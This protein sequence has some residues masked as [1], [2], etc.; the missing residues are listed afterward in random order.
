MAKSIPRRGIFYGWLILGVCFFAMFV[1]STRNGFGV[2]ILPM[3]EEFN[4][5]RGT[6]SLAIAIGMLVNGVS[7]PFLGRLH[8]RFGARK[9]LSAGLFLMGGCTMLLSQTNSIWFLLVI[10]GFVM[11]IAA[12]A[13]SM[14]VVHAALSRWFY[15]KRGIA[16]SVSTAGVSLGS[17]VLAPF[18]TYMIL[19]WD[20]R[21]AWFVLG[22]LILFLALPLVILLF[23]DNPADVGEVPDGGAAQ[24]KRGDQRAAQGVRRGPLEVDNW[25]D[26]YK[27]APM[28]QLNGA[29][30]VCGMTTAIIAAHYVPFAVERGASPETAALAFGLMMGLN[31]VGVLL[32][33]ALSDRLGRK[34][35]LGTVYAI[36]GL[37]YAVLLLVPGP[38]SLWGFA[39][40]TGI[41][42]IASAPLTTS[43]TAEIYGVKNMGTLGGMVTLAHQMGSALSIYMGGLLYDITGSYILPFAIAGGMLA[44]ASLAS[45]AIKERKYSAKY[46]PA[47]TE[48]TPAPAAADGN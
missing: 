42:W 39:V 35:V 43:L 34:N 26:S 46:Q 40:I 31:I 28:W 18:A 24:T 27:T 7:Q 25:R 30:F 44:G 36:R 19:L 29:Y 38:W 23:R 47:I 5:S 10:Y 13:A 33:G 14:V 15:R 11:S 37:G 2:F 4:W 1:S 32:A 45:Y 6:I 48:P 21:V 9:V 3:S 16:L 22:A 12:S 17:L 20:W 8:D 41:S